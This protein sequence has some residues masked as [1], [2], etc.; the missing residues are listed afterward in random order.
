MT[1]IVFALLVGLFANAVVAF[2]IAFFWQ[3]RVIITVYRISDWKNAFLPWR[4]LGNP[5]SPQRTM[6]RFVAGEILPDMRRK[7]LRS[8][9]Y[10]VLS[11]VTLFV[12]LGLLELM[13]RQYVP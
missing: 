6:G 2:C 11:Y 7:W 12:I 10:V 13:A 1:A 3:A 8:L 4:A 5:N 9:I